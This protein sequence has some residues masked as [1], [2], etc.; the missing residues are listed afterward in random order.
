M[1]GAIIK[2]EGKLCTIIGHNNGLFSYILE[3]FEEELCNK[4]GEPQSRRQFNVIE[5]SKQWK[6]GAQPVKTLPTN[7]N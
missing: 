7:T 5:S 1:I 2:F 4:C 3:E 6:D